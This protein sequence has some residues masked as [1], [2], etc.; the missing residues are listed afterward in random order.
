MG[1]KIAVLIMVIGLGL[2]IAACQP[3]APATE[4]PP[5]TQCPEP[6]PCP[7]VPDLSAEVPF[8][9]LWSGSGHANREAEAFN[10]WNEESP[11]EIP[12]TCA[13]CHSSTG[14]Q[15]F[16]GADGSAAG[17]VDK[18]AAIGTVITC[19]T[20]HNQATLSYT[21]VKFPSGAEI[22]G[23]GREALCM[24]C[25]Q[26]AASSV[27]VD[28][29]IQKA[30]A[31]DEDKPVAE[32]GFTN[33]HYFAAAVARYGTLVKGGYQYPGKS[34]DG[35]WEHVS[36]FDTCIGCH[37]AHSLELKVDSCA[38]CH[39]GVK[40]AEDVRK[41]RMI[42]S[43]KDYDG[44]GDVTEGIYGEVEGLRQLLLTAIQSYAKEVAGTP[45]AYSAQAY[46]Y[47]FIDTNANGEA[48]QD[49]AAF[50]NRYASWTPR[51]A[52]AAFN[53]QAAT[54]DPGAYVHGGKYIIQLLYDSIENLNE[55]LSAPVDLSKAFRDDPGH[56]MGSSEAFR[57]WDAEGVVPGACAKCH[58]SSGV[59]TF[60]VEGV[61]VSTK[62]ADGLKC[63]TC[64]ND[65][66]QFTIYE[67]K[68]VAFP[69]GASLSFP[70]DGE[71]PNQAN[72]CLVCHQGRESTVS[73]NRAI[74]GQDLDKVNEKL[75]FRNVHYFAAGST[76]F[77]TSAKGAYEYK[78][79][80]Y[81]DVFQHVQGF[82]T[83]VNCHDV[84]TQ[85]V[86]TDACKGCHQTDDPATIRMKSDKDYDGDGDAKEGLQAELEGMAEVLY[87]AIQA[88]AKDVVQKPI[89]YSPAAYPYFFNDSN[90]NG[91]V[92]PEEVNFD[93]RYASWT[94]R[95]LQAAYNYQYVQ[96]DPGAFAH[97]FAYVGQV[98]FDSITDLQSKVTVEFKGVRP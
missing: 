21:T 33:I 87:A 70:A 26:G 29:A 37:N 93:N 73:V 27:Q 16:V 3:T 86:N 55:K 66:T 76:L 95:L 81:A 24:T 69:S 7:E 88:Y 94:P 60:A 17:A 80:T 6:A 53:F 74:A 63:E 67:F 77:G 89:V 54:K 79:K 8:Y 47:F 35:L 14:F 38:S 43:S 92:D 83:C 11:A 59:P 62:P 44:D 36:G 39:Q 82:S 71:K 56:F 68:A 96:K 15:D 4:A 5:P 61:N 91:K 20:C 65:L 64:H 32:L 19:Q 97:N 49:E 42:S 57:H 72:L 22:S 51:L 25:H 75:S 1:R 84:H 52:K 58:S 9:A 45:I 50:P 31:T 2:L 48:D 18:P 78:D 28:E 41:I 23:L 10:H 13:K 40:S 12:Q 30:N 98:V 90:G 34:Y 85:Q 46:P